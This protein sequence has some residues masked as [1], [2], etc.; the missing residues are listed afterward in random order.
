MQMRLRQFCLAAAELEPALEVLA[1]LLDGEVCFR[2]P[3]V[4]A[5][6]LH[7]GLLA[8]GGDFI[9]VVSP[10]PQAGETAAG[11]HIARRG[12]SG[13]MVILQCADG[14][15][16]RTHICGQ[17]VR[18]IWRNDTNGIAATHFHPR[19][20]GGAIVS[21]DSMGDSTGDSTGQEDWRSPR[22]YWR[23]AGTGWLKR[24]NAQGTGALRELVIA[25]AEP[26]ALAAHWAKLL[27]LPAAAKDGNHVIALEGAELVFTAGGGAPAPVGLALAAGPSGAE[28]FLAR[29]RALD[30]PVEADGVRFCGI[31]WRAV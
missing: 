31:N 12:D 5:F 8:T 3:G 6:G 15:A 13:Y 14:L 19:D 11:R 26:E 27:Q 9:E 2:D 18:D 17:G 1:G 30:L 20:F 7:N 21:I 29:A 16:A 10:L 28:G 24:Q 23:W 4:A 22:A 25:A